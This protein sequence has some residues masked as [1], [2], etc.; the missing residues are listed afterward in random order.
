MFRSILLLLLDQDG[1]DLAAQPFLQVL[2]LQQGPLHLRLDLA[3][4]F[5]VVI[6]DLRVLVFPARFCQGI[7][8]D[9][10]FEDIRVHCKGQLHVEAVAVHQ[11]VNDGLVVLLFR[12]HALRQ[13]FFKFLRVHLIAELCHRHA[14]NFFVVLKKDHVLV[15]GTLRE[16]LRR[17]SRRPAGHVSAVD[18]R[19]NQELTVVLHR[20][21]IA[22]AQSG[23][24]QDD[25]RRE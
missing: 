15:Q 18:L 21:Q 7:Q 9:R 6:E 23:C 13:G 11:R 24:G 3:L 20:A 12:F 1:I 19:P 25:H 4:L 17:F 10:F 2:F 16:E 8:C 22:D 5:L 14:E